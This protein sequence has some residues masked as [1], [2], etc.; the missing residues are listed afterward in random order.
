MNTL[1]QL[2]VSGTTVLVRVDFNV[3]LDGQSITDDT[4][5][6]AAVPTI[7]HLLEQGADKV[8]LMSHLGRPQVARSTRPL[9][10]GPI[11]EHLGTLL[12]AARRLPQSDRRRRGQES[13]CRGRQGLGYRSRKHPFRRAR[14]KQRRRLRPGARGPSRRLRQRRLWSCPPRPRLDGRRG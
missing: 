13:H 9:S 8:V 10:L 6:Q 14:E 1:D 5:I 7:Q 3:P 4:R 11:A 12:D 2:D